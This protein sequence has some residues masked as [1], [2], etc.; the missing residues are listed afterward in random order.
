[1]LAYLLWDRW[2]NTAAPSRGIGLGSRCPSFGSTGSSNG[3]FIAAKLKWRRQQ[4]R[5][6]NFA[7]VFIARRVDLNPS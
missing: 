6:R 7:Y 3:L 2:P 1:M 5:V 4:Y